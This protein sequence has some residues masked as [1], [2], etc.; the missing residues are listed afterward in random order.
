MEI[1]RPKARKH[2][3]PSHNILQG[4]KLDMRERERD[5]PGRSGWSSGI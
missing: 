1:V 3:L 4:I 2:I 5:E